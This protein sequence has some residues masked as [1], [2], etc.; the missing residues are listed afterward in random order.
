MRPGRERHRVVR[1]LQA[2]DGGCLACRL[3]GGLAA[4]G[5]EPGGGGGDARRQGGEGRHRRGPAPDEEA[6]AAQDHVFLPPDIVCRRRVHRGARGFLQGQAG[7]GRQ[8]HGADVRA[9]RGGRGRQHGGPVVFRQFLH[10]LADGARGRRAAPGHARRDAARRQLRH[11]LRCGPARDNRRQA[12][13]HGA[14]VQAQG[15]G[16]A[17]HTR[18]RALRRHAQHAHTALRGQ[19]CQHARAQHVQ[20]G[21][22]GVRGRRH[23]FRHQH[24]RRGRLFRGGVDGGERFFRLPG[25]AQPHPLAHV[26]RGQGQE[27]EAGALYAV[28]R[29]PA[30]QDRPT[31]V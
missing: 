13:A 20:Q 19:R 21:E 22:C 25:H 15:R 9:L 31:G 27:A 12:P 16:G 7:G 24:G 26:Q 17:P 2:G 18:L 14:A 28:L 3:A 1:W 8:R 10:I 29:Q 11:L 6:E 4:H 5:R 30:A 23:V